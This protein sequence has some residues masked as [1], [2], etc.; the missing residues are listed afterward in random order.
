MPLLKGTGL[1]IVNLFSQDAGRD[2]R[3]ALPPKCTAA[4]P[5]CAGIPALRRGPRAAF[6]PALFSFLLFN[7]DRNF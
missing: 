2:G 1:L 6:L 7:P 3:G 4:P 5:L